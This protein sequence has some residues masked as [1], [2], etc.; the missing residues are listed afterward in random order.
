MLNWEGKGAPTAYNYPSQAWHGKDIKLHEGDT[1][2]DTLT[3]DVYTCSTGKNFSLRVDGRSVQG[4][5]TQ[6]F[7]KIGDGADLITSI[8]TTWKLEFSYYPIWTLTNAGNVTI[9]WGA[10]ELQTNFRYVQVDKNTWGEVKEITDIVGGSISR[11][12]L[13]A[14]KEGATLNY[15]NTAQLLGIGNDYLRVYLDADDGQRQESIA[16]GTYKVST[17]Q[18]TMSD[19]GTSGSATCYSVLELVQFEGLDGQI[20]IP[21]GTNLIEY[22]AQL[23]ESRGLNVD[24]QGSSSVTAKND[25]FFDAENSILDVVTW[26]TQASNFGTPLVDGYGTVLLQ[27]YTDPTYNSPS[28]IY[29][30]DSRV[31]FPEYAHEL[32]TFSMPNK[33][34]VVCSTPDEVI[35]GTAVNTDPLSPYSTV[36]RGFV[37]SA[38]YDVDNL[39]DETAANAK[40]ADLL[41]SLSLVESVEVEHLYNG[42]NLRDVF[43]VMDMGNYATVN[44]DISLE[45]GC[46]V[47]DRGRR[48]VGGN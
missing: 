32:D 4:T 26:C 22:A 2:T 44:Q 9:N 28:I 1:Y 12:Y 38:R 10:P 24:I 18:Q 23:L 20:V 35:T 5:D 34:I 37:I 46:P 31:M 45:T 43:G 41:R 39:A 33:V 6:T 7:T 13:S 30:K 15:E 14:V 8:P 17:P 11:K 29:D 16:L 40:A 27:P 19:K 48:F 3:G 42:S 25:T 21:A 36:S 47:K